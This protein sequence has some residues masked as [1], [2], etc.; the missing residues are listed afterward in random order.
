MENIENLRS[1]NM[2]LED[3]L[4][5]NTYSNNGGSAGLDDKQKI[6]MLENEISQLRNKLNSYSSNNDMS[7]ISSNKYEEKMQ[8]V[9]RDYLEQI[10]RLKSENND[11]KGTDFL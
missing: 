8:K 3:Q 11:L 4:L 2:E 7:R 1:K 5:K 9:V 6:M 10:E